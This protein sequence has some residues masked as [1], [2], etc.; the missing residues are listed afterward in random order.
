MLDLKTEIFYVYILSFITPNL[1]YHDV[2]LSG[3]SSSTMKTV[4]TFTLCVSS[5]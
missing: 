4:G 3:L 2:K 1:I 5:R